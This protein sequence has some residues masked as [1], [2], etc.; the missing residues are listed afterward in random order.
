MRQIR[1]FSILLN[2]CIVA[3]PAA[4]AGS[5]ELG[6][7]VGHSAPSLS[8]FESSASDGST[9]L[10][11]PGPIF[12]ARF[13][14]NF[15]RYLGYELS[16]SNQGLQFR[17][18]ANENPDERTPHGPRTVGSVSV[19]MHS[20]SNNLVV[21][22]RRESATVRP[23]AICGLELSGLAVPHVADPEHIGLAVGGGLI[24]GGG[25][26]VVLGRWGVGLDVR[27]RFASPEFSS[28]VNNLHGRPPLPRRLNTLALTGTAFWN[29]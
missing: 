15:A 28:A 25:V 20:V 18:S 23:F 29:F 11:A 2:S 26:K 4:L 13:S 19:R 24:F 10:V 27:Q 9:I 3:V 8:Y 16:Y 22:A 21:H 6:F 7:S 12:G 5:K 17:T 14:W 1:L